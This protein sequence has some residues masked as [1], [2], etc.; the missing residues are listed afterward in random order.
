MTLCKFYN[1]Q[2][3]YSIKNKHLNTRVKILVRWRAHAS[4]VAREMS[5]PYIGQCYG[6]D[7]SIMLVVHIVTYL[8]LILIMYPTYVFHKLKR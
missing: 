1:I 2:T 6:C 4:E 8:L 5:V 3:E 7:F